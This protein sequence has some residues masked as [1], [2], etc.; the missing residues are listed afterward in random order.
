VYLSQNH[1]YLNYGAYRWKFYMLKHRRDDLWQRT[2]YLTP[3]RRDVTRMPS[4]TMLVLAG[5]D[6]LVA[7]FLESGRC[8]VV[9]EVTGAAG[10]KASV[11]LRVRA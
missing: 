3:D 2:G 11:I 7:T 10:S 4:G 8:S 9:K 5:N 1:E 6:P